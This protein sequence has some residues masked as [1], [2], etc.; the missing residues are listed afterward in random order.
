MMH[1]KRISKYCRRHRVLNYFISG[2][3]C[4]INAISETF[5]GIVKNEKQTGLKRV[6]GN[7]ML[8][9]FQTLLF[10]FI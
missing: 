4:T 1:M 10:C 5:H 6:V 8:L 7:S 2:W 9:I 3:R